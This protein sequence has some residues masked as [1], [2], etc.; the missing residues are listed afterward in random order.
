MKKE[1]GFGIHISAFQIFTSFYV[2]SAVFRGLVSQMRVVFG[3]AGLII[4]SRLSLG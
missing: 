2:A 3:L 4:I 1:V